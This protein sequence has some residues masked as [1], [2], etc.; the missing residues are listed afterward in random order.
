MGRGKAVA[1]VRKHGVSFDFAR[2]IFND[3]PLLTVAVL[4]HSETEERWFSIGRAANGSIFSI[5]YVRSG[6]KPATKIRIIGS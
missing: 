4:E 3:P 2:T 6:G 5:A 1:N